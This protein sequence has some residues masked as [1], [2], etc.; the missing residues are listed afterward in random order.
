[1]IE[2][3]QPLH[4]AVPLTVAMPVYNEEG[5]IAAAVSEVQTY[6][7]DVVPGSELVVVNDGSK[8]NTGRLLDEAARQDPRVRVVHQTNK[9]HGGALMAALGS[10]R[11][12]YVFLIDSD[13]QIPLNDFPAAWAE[14]Q[15][16]RDAVFGLRRQRHDSALRLQLTRVVRSAVGL[17]FGVR[18]FDANVPYKLLRRSIWDEARAHIPSD[19]LA[20]SLF[21]AIYARSR[22]F[23]V[24]DID[25]SH[26]ERNTGVVSIRRLKLF[27]F[28][29]R[30]L[31]QML[32]FRRSLRHAG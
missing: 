7:L 14:T 31:R 29:A 30:G 2:P 3:V 19:T 21:L 6:V 22:G 9:G 20:P 32:A 16:G 12:D 10:A 4:G 18:I 1:M 26:R 28:C 24:V 5:A 25:V 27:K 15:R 17:L 11:G 8:D 13:R 23:D